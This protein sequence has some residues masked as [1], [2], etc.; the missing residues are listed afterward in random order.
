MISISRCYK[1]SS[2]NHSIRYGNFDHYWM[3]SPVFSS[4]SFFVCEFHHC[5]LQILQWLKAAQLRVQFVIR[6]HILYFILFYRWRQSMHFQQF[7]SK[8]TENILLPVMEWTLY[9][10]LGW[11]GTR[12]FRQGMFMLSITGWAVIKT[13]FYLNECK[14]AHLL[15]WASCPDSSISMIDQLSSCWWLTRNGGWGAGGAG[16]RKR[17]ERAPEEKMNRKL[18]KTE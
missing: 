14:L 2:I 18:S 1:W 8:K 6:C 17:D 3:S 15:W 11:M 7:T 16:G 12:S 4:E 13:H 5:P 10:A 9:S